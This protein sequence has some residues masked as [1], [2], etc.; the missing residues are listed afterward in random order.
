MIK[1]FIININYN[2]IGIYINYLDIMYLDFNKQF[3]K[4]F[5]KR[6]GIQKRIL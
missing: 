1:T 2:F 3:G 6:L 4:F 5:N